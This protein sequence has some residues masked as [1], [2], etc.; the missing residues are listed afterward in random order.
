[1]TSRTPG[2]F[3][4]AFTAGACLL[5]LPL[6]MVRGWNAAPPITLASSWVAEACFLFLLCALGIWVGG[7]RRLRRAL[8]G[9]GLFVLVELPTLVVIAVHTYYLQESVGRRWALLDATPSMLRYFFVEIVQRHVLWSAV[10]VL[11]ALCAVAFVVSRRLAAPPARPALLLLSALSVAVLVHQARCP[12]YPSVLWEVGVDL[13]EVMSH[14]AVSGP[15]FSQM[16]EDAGQG[17]PAAWPAHSPFDKVIVFVMESVPL[18]AF[19]DQT[20]DVPTDGFFGRSRQHTHAYRNY[21]TTNQDSRTGI[22]SMLFSRPV[23]F[24]AYTEADV[25]GYAFLRGERSLVDDMAERGYTTAVAI[26]QIDEDVVVHE[27]P[28]WRDKLMLSEQEYAHPGRYLCLNPYQ[29]EQGCEDQILLPRIFK[30]LDAH[31][32]LFL[33]QEAIYG[34]DGAYEDTIK[35]SPVQY[36]D[37]HLRAIEAHLAARGE[38]DRTLIVVTSDHG[39]RDSEDR[40]RR[41]VYRLP[42]LLINPRFTRAEQPGLYNQSDFGAL[43]AAEMAGVPA[44]PPRTASLFVGPTNTSILGSVTAGGDLLVIRHRKLSSYVLVDGHCPDDDVPTEQP[45]DGVSPAALLNRFQGLREAFRP[46]GTGTPAPTASTGKR[47]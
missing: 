8:L 17:R 26:S 14:R 6:K 41:W 31:T 23:P 40:S 1:M 16:L 19:E 2:A 5:L 27:L 3:R 45:R 12:F 37:E 28:S 7:S 35:K 46:G 36:Y 43:L 42:L 47:E 13:A 32:R 30:E 15:M 11:A 44:P 29:F 10:G 38:L 20:R 24:E 22:M 18:R 33:F 21:F 25:A 34:H 39:L 4:F 9:G